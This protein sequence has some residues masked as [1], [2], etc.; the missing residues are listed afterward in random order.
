MI[1]LWQRRLWTIGA[2]LLAVMFASLGLAAVLWFAG[3]EAGDQFALGVAAF[4]GLGFVADLMVFVVYSR[5]TP[6]TD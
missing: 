1:G 3:D 6:S 5:T 4:A 2:V